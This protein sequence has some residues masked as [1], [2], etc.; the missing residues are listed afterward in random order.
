M[1]DNPAFAIFPEIGNGFV[2]I[3]NNNRDGIS[4]SGYVPFASGG[5]MGTRV[6]EIVVQATGTTAAGLARVYISGVGIVGNPLFDE[7]TIAVAAPS[8]SVKATRISTTY[9][10]L[11]LMSGQILS[12]TNSVGPSQGFNIIALGA[13]L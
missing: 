10:N 5:R 3:L 11:V 8:A 6:A 7:I 9:N 12:A 13:D 1:A 4:G 2:T